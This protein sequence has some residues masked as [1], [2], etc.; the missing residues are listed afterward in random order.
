[1]KSANTTNSSNYQSDV[2]DNSLYLDSFEIGGIQLKPV[3]LLEHLLIT[4]G[5]GSGKTRSLLLPLV[6]KLLLRF[7]TDAEQ[8]A[9]MFLI[10]AKGDMSRLAVECARRAG[11]EDDVYILGEGG[12]CWF[13]LF[14]QFNGDVTRIANFLFETLEDRTSKGLPGRGGSNDSF[15]EENSRRLLRAAVTLTKA[16]HGRNIE[17]S[18]ISASVN[19]ILA[20][21]GTSPSFDDDDSDNGTAA[22]EECEET[23]EQGLRKGWITVDESVSFG[24]YLVNDV[25]GGNDRT[26]TTIA[27]MTR[28]YLAQFS[29]PTLQKIFN[30]DPDKKRIAPEDIIDRGALLIVSLSPVL[31]GE[32]AAPYR[33]AVKKA[34]CERMLQ[35]DHLLTMDNSGLRKMNSQRPVLFVCD[36]FHT[37]LH[38][39]QGGEA[40]FLDR[41]REFRCMCVLATQG[42]SAIQSVLHNPSQC[43]HLLNNC[44]TKVFF[45]N[46]CPQTTEYFERIGGMEDRQIESQSFTPRI[47]PAR[48]RL[49]NHNYIRPSAM[50]MEAKSIGVHR[51]P[52]FSAAELGCLPNGT[53]FV[54]T[55]GRKLKTYTKNPAD[56]AM[57]PEE[58]NA[59]HS[60]R[61][62]QQS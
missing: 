60:S 28:N 51:L 43:D 47:A 19:M 8:K 61:D 40:Y 31:Y 52:K 11:R 5:T 2:Y 53:A 62:T 32:A 26:W 6:E 9:G 50:R 7:G 22:T 24:L 48:F 15:W 1:M 33:V 37:T 21:K 58:M 3:D 55:K 42:I 17:L 49:P 18:N 54:V 35:R 14:D 30:A 57:S 12:N 10:D 13:P 36:E 46:D 4:G 44:R 16:V 23:I 29:Q 56:Y 39:G 38:A 34:F 27:N 45:A 41:A 59:P 25:K 20:A